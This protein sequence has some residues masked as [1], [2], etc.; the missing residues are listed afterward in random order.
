MKDCPK[1]HPMLSDYLE[2][3]LKPSEA[4][5]VE[6]HLKACADARKELD[7]QRRLREVLTA[8][9]EP[10]MPHDLHDKIMAKLQGRPGPLRAHRPF[11]VVPAGVM[12]LAA[13]I[14]VILLVQN[15]D[16]LSLKAKNKAV[17]ASGPEL[18]EKAAPPPPA[19]KPAAVSA[20]APNPAGLVQDL[21]GSREESNRN[22]VDSERAGVSRHRETRI[23]KKSFAREM[24]VVAAPAEEQAKAP[25]AA[26][27]PPSTLSF[28]GATTE[29]QKASTDLA[30][31]PQAFNMQAASAPQPEA[32]AAP[33]AAAAPEGASAAPAPS[34]VTSWGGSLSPSTPEL[35]QLVTDEGTFQKYWQTLQ[36]GQAEPSVDFTTQ[37]VVVLMD[38]E[39][40]S[41]GY[42][43]RVSSLEEKPDQFVVHYQVQAP[44]P[45]AATAQVLTRPWAVQIIPKPAKPVGF[46]KDS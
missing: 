27:P 35:Q 19:S 34:P 31:A 33:R 7:G 23:A 11:W 30:N 38:Q 2:G 41:N 42:S 20:G 44:A 8:L 29:Q 13:S 9:P 17:P 5:R 18:K 24:P 36:P 25:S 4:A 12:A 15:P 40:P 14:T 32:A 26:L 45:G 37:A 46:Q 16:M 21:G 10:P 39:R 3:L 22:G 28:Q 1:I 43:I 6:A